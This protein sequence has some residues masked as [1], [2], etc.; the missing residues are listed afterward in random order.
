MKHKINKTMAAMMAALLG[1]PLAA[2]AQSNVTLGGQV[3]QGVDHI[4]YS[5]GNAAGPGSATRVTDN[6]SYLYFKGDEDLGGG[7]KAFFHLE[8]GFASDV[9]TFGT[10]RFSAVG[11]SNPAWGRI[12]L[13]QWSTY[14]AS[15]SLLSPGGLRD[16]GP[17]ASGTLNVLGSIGKR[18]QYFAGGFLPNTLRYE[19]PNWGGL[20]FAT[21]YSFD[22][23][24]P[25]QG[26]NHTF[27]LNPTYTSGPLMLY[28]NHLQRSDQPGAPGSFATS[29]DQTADRL[30]AG[31]QFDSGIKVALLVDRNTVQGSAI[32][33]GKLSRDAWAIP[34]SYRSGLH[35][36]SLTL[37]QAKSYKTAGVTTANTG[38][39][40]FSM[41]Y[42][43]ALS[44]R[45]FLAANYSTMRNDSKAA[46][47]FWYPSNT[48][49]LAAG[50][51]GF[52]SRLF[53]AGLKHTF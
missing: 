9:G 40:M 16:A 2:L 26:A 6:S 7:N 34:V 12:L 11:L 14:F 39:K 51:T 3:K 38:A 42:E 32:A 10:P 25:N 50:Y 53:Y 35:L 24:T 28:A 46:Y 43:Y 5:G 37:G 49:P 15:D 44:K 33:G 41:G 30:G 20:A 22:T 36:F 19:S 52:N 48:L 13:G 47:D 21:S 31:Y 27:N 18:S 8:W 45:T 17:Y 23:E 4:S 1:T 29:Y